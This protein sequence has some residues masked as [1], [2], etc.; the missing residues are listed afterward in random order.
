MFSKKNRQTQ[1]SIINRSSTVSLNSV[2]NVLTCGVMVL[3][4]STSVAK[5]QLV[6]TTDPEAQLA[7]VLCR[8]PTEEATDEQLLDK[9]AQFVT[10]TLWKRLLECAFSATGPANTGQVVGDL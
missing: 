6:Q 4:A 9:N 8:N 7:S 1:L 3:L 5:A 2:M 10:V